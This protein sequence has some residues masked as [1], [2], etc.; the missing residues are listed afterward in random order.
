MWVTQGNRIPPKNTN[1]MV[2][3]GVTIEG[4][5]ELKVM[6]SGTNL[7]LVELKLKKG[8][9][10]PRHNHPEHESI[11]YVITGALEMTIGDQTYYLG[12]GDAWHHGIGV[13]HSTKALED[14][15]AIEAHSP[16]RDEYVKLANE[17][18]KVRS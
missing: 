1:G 14:T 15:Y 3:G 13:P 12:P 2:V 4:Q 11:G 8:Y 9:Y 17:Q 5:A 10:H 6:T 7:Q 18:K 16:L